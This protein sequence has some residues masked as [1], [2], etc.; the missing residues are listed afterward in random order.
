MKN[1]FI[2][3]FLCVLCFIS[4]KSNN[5]ETTT[6]KEKCQ[7]SSFYGKSV[8]VFGGSV[9]VITQSKAGKDIWKDYLN[10]DITDYGKSGYGFSSLQGSIQTEV[11]NCGVHDVYILW[12]ST[13]DFTNNREAGKV[14]DYT[15]KDQHNEKKK[16]T[17]CGG[18]NYCI[19]KI[20]EKNPNAIILFFISLPFFYTEAGYN[21]I[22]SVHNNK[23]Y[24]FYDYIK[25]QRQCCEYNKIPYLDQ[26]NLKLFDINNCTQYY[27]SDKLHPTEAAYKLLA[28]YQILFFLQSS[29]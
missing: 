20:R 14:T 3:L 12:A 22:S 23:G 1:K 21:E 29:K 8:A 7:Q 10:W 9:S 15:E 13:N 16:E 4:C 18:I 19:K 24:N 2:T 28:N 11:E 27:Q 6:L 25:L 26:W 5:K 17:Q